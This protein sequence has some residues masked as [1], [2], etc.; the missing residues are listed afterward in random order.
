MSISSALGIGASSLAT[1]QRAMDV[2]AHNIANVNTPG[3]SRQRADLATLAP[4]QTMGFSFGRGATIATITRQVDLSIQRALGNSASQKQMWTQVTQGLSAIENVFGSL[5]AT[6]LSASFDHFFASWQ[7]LANSPADS[8]QKINVGVA[9][10]EL[11]T[12]LANMRT[13][14]RTEQVNIDQQIDQKISGANLL[15]KQIASLNVQIVRQEI[16]G[17]AAPA[18]DLRDQREQALQNLSAIIPIQRVVNPDGSLLV[19]TPGGD[20]LAQDDI[21]HQLS[22]G[23]SV[24]ASGFQ[25]I[26]LQSSPKVPLAGISTGGTIGGMVD[27]RDN[28]YGTYL[29][30]LDSVSKNL[31]FGSNQIYSNGSSTNRSTTASAGQPSLISSSSRTS[32]ITSQQKVS[33]ST[34]SLANSGVPLASQITTGSFKLVAYNSSGDQS[35]SATINIKPTDTLDTVVAAVNGAGIGATA[36]VVNGALELKATGTGASLAVTAD[37]SKFLETF[38]INSALLDTSGVPFASQIKAGSF[39]LHLYDSAGKPLNVAGVSIAIDPAVTMLDDRAFNTPPATTGVIL[40]AGKSVIGG[41]DYTGSALPSGSFAVG[42]SLSGVLVSDT[43]STGSTAFPIGTLSDGTNTNAAI[44]TLPNDGVTTLKSAIAATVGVGISGVATNYT[45]ASVGTPTPTAPAT[46]GLV[47]KSGSVTLDVTYPPVTLPTGSFAA[48]DSVSNTMISAKSSSGSIT[49]PIGSLSDGST[50]NAVAVTLPNDGSTTLGAA[51]AATSGVGQLSTTLASYTMVASGTLPVTTGTVLGAGQVILG[52]TA[53]V[54]TTLPSGSFLSGDSLSGT[55]IS[56]PA[57]SSS[58]TFPAGTLS[59]GTNSNAVAVTLPNDGSTTLQAAIAATTGVGTLS[60]VATTYTIGA[61]GTPP[62]TT[63]VVIGAGS[64]SLGTI[65]P[66]ATLPTGSFSV[67]DSLSGTLTSA[68]GSTGNVV[69]PA[70]TLSDGTYANL[71][72]VTLPNDGSTTLSAAIAATTGVGSI[73]TAS[74]TTYTVENGGSSSSVV[75]L[76]NQAVRAYNH[77]KSPSA[78]PV[79][80][81]TLAASTTNGVLKLDTGNSGQTIGFSNDTSNFLAA[82]E[83]NALFHGSDTTNLAVDSVVAN[84]S[85]RINTGTIDAATSNIYVAD[86]QTASAMFSLQQTSFSV[87]GTVATSLH[88]RNSD[89]SAKYGLDVA[90]AQ[91]QLTY[92]TAEFNSLTA[93]RDAVSGVNMDEELINMIKF[94]RAYQSSAKIITTVNTMLDSLMG[95]IR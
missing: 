40:A 23:T 10:N 76:I 14:L 67:G 7:Q 21:A 56:T 95:L 55:L 13:Q 77:P 2:L 6:G 12:T 63:G 3:Y 31:I 33:V 75:G 19:Q 70:G 53:Y 52:G 35:G 80:L 39:K 71:V 49:F 9:A 72:S 34:I 81:L 85:T 20:L 25:E 51:I 86:N 91:R 93:Q 8:A 44:V 41:V 22:R 69:F 43:T 47:V 11:V 48:G 37:S 30:T 38:G 61:T 82:Y 54:P 64:I 59:D 18:N 4:E 27:L 26:V 36:S 66:A 84:D 24:T 42:D 74:T 94:Q 57:S 88:Q 15:I 46:T 45:I 90:N 60:S 79:T 87:D 73:A 58:I 5:S 50:T 32:S 17:S 16:N 28:R 78:A 68:T 65:Y 92:R 1:Q 83:I 62:A 89:L 29:S